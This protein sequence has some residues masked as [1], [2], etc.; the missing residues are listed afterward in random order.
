MMMMT[1]TRDRNHHTNGTTGKNIKIPHGKIDGTND[2]D[3]QQNYNQN[4]QRCNQAIDI[5]NALC[6][7]IDGRVLRRSDAQHR[8]TFYHDEVML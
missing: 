5:N 8:A 1:T 6:C 7:H 2:D 3:H 4:H